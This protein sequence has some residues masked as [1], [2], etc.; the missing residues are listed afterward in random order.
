MGKIFN[1]NKEE[2]IKIAPAPEETETLEENKYMDNLSDPNE[3]P[4]DN[5]QMQYKE[6]PVCLSQTQINNLIIDNNIMLKQL[7]SLD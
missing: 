5:P 4:T 1:K 3:S 6:I 2:E 7:I